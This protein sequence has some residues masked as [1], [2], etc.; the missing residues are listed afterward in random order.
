LP[1]SWFSLWNSIASAFTI[2]QKW[3]NLRLRIE[4]EASKAEAG[5]KKK[6][7]TSEAED[8]F[9]SPDELEK[10]L[11]RIKWYVW[12]GNAHDAISRLEELQDDLVWV[13]EVSPAIQKLQQAVH[14]LYV[15]MTT[16]QSLLVNYGN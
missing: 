3:G 16:N 11:E 7:R 8:S 10:Q 14:E 4:R 5:K 13:E 15:H 1:W 2:P 9:P 6:K 12:H